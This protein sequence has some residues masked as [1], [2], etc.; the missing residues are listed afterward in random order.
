MDV[1]GDGCARPPLPVLRLG[2]GH[3]EHAGREI[4]ADGPGW[5][6]AGDR[7][8][9]VPCSTGDVEDA[10]LPALDRVAG[11]PTSPCLVTAQGME[12]IVQVVSPGDRIEHPPHTAGLVP[13][14]MR[15]GGKLRVAPGGCVGVG[16]GGHHLQIVHSGL[17]E[18]GGPPPFA[19]IRGC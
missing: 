16:L 1:L 14:V 4:D 11:G 12:A 6:K 7:L 8:G 10:V 19:T 13:R 3:V 18:R 9:E 2:D 17:Q 5:P 15:V